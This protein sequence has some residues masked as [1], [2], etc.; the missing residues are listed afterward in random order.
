MMKPQLLLIAALLVLTSCHQEKMHHSFFDFTADQRLFASYCFMNAAGFD[1]DWVEEMHPIRMEVR[2]F[3]DSVLSEEYLSE[4][5]DYY[6]ERGGGNFYAYGSA[7]LQLGNPPEFSF[8]GDA[9]DFEYLEAFSDYNDA[10]R[11]FYRLAH[12]EELWGRYRSQLD[13][14]NLS[15]EPFAKHAISQITE[16]CRVQPNFYANIARTIRYQQMPLMSHWTAFFSE[17]E[18][19]Y[20]IVTGPSTAAPGP[21]AFYHEALHRIINPIVEQNQDI[22]AKIDSLLPYAQD[23]LKGDYNSSTLIL[24]ES[25][26]RSIDKILSGRYYEFSQDQLKAKIEDEY[27]LGHIVCLYLLESLP[28]YESSE[29]TL[30]E[31]YPE[32]ISALDVD[33]EIERWKRYWADQ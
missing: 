32:L 23:K 8:T 25:F 7:A 5:Q 29:R 19:E 28:Q 10:L 16:Y 30:E 15:Y 33:R 1:H 17:V 26:V 21:G 24:C 20:W 13:S 3:L 9:W 4:I 2:A 31:Y 6:N 18:D 11:K 22:N 14:I 27:R 12:V